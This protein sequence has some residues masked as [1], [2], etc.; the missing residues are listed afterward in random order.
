LVQ[1]VWWRDRL[2]QQHDGVVLMVENFCIRALPTCSREREK[3]RAAVRPAARVG[4]ERSCAPALPYIGGWAASL[5]PPPSLRAG[6]Q[7]VEWGGGQVFPLPSR[8]F[9]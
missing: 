7:G 9:P 4:E 1:Q 2:D 8:T 6:G 3:W 5:A